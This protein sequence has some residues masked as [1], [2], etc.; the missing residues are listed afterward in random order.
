MDTDD[1][2]C[3]NTDGKHIVRGTEHSQE[4]LWYELIRQKANKGKAECNEHADLDRLDHTLFV[5]GTVIIGNDWCNT[6]IKTKH[7]HK[8]E[9]LQLKINTK[10]CSCSNR[11]LYQD[12]IHGISHNGADGLHNDGRNTY[13]IN[14]TDNCLIRAEASEIKTNLR[15]KLMVADPGNNAG[16][17]LADH[18]GNSCSCNSHSRCSQETE[19]QNRIQDNVSECTT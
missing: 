15:I 19:N 7:R 12:Q 3:R 8:E 10:Y 6:V 17:K 18:C 4:S 13:C 9:A 11:K 2:K 14:M 16:Y 1:P 5:T